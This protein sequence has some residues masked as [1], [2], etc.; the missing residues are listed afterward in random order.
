MKIITPTGN[1]IAIAYFAVEVYPGLY[2]ETNNLA[3]LQF[4]VMHH[5]DGYIIPM[6]GHRDWTREIEETHEVLFVQSKAIEVRFKEG[7]WETNVV[8]TKGD[9]I[10]LC[11]GEHEIEFYGD[12]QVVEVKQGPY[13]DR[14]VDK[15]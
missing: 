15:R 7:E 8:L 14:G 3:P 13:F 11:G 6:H 12:A 5:P 1:L 10:L 9:A 4:G 2:F